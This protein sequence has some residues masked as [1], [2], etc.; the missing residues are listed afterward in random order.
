VVWGGPGL[1][2]RSPVPTFWNA[3]IVASS[4]SGASG[5]IAFARSFKAFVAS[6]RD[7]NAASHLKTNGFS[8]NAT[9][10]RPIGLAAS[11][12]LASQRDYR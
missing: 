11:N 9:W 12:Y 10:A 3:S 2:A 1:T 8:E 7:L 6:L 5:F 4:S